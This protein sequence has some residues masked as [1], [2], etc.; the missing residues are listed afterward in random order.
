MTAK[1]DRRSEADLTPWQ[2]LANLG[3]SLAVV[4]RE[5]RIIWVREP[6]AGESQDRMIGRRC[7][8]VFGDGENHCGPSCPVAPVL[9]GGQ[10]VRTER[11]FIDPRG[12]ERWREAR[13]FP[14]VDNQGR[15]IYVARISFDITQRKEGEARRRRNREA[16]EQSIHRLDRL[17][18]SQS[19]FQPGPDAALSP[20]ELE[21]LRLL[22]QG[23]NNPQLARLLGI[24]VNTVKRHVGNIFNKLG[25]GDRTQ[26][27]VWAARNGLA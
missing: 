14:I 21:V 7:Y 17:Q 15:L 3:D 13:A 11:R 25:V 26:A 9:A 20:R 22:A 5:Y 23:A 18:L 10:P 6:L 2:V 16:L 1:D 8:T 24:S 27:A 4:D 19:P 12:R